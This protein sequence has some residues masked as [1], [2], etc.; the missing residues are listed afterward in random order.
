ML[1]WFL[2]QAGVDLSSGF[3]GVNQ[4]WIWPGQGYRSFCIVFYSNKIDLAFCF[5]RTFSSFWLRVP[6]CFVRRLMKG[7]ST[8]QSGRGIYTFLRRQERNEEGRLLYSICDTT[9]DPAQSTQSKQKTP[10]QVEVEVDVE[11]GSCSY[12][13]SGSGTGTGTRSRPVNFIHGSSFISRN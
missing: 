11:S 8:C 3:Q 4:C 1:G 10:Y 9:Q 2:A 12:S 13:G 6:V 7:D 5:N